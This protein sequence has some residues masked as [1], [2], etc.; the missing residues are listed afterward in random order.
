MESKINKQLNSEQIKK[1]E[2]ELYN[3]IYEEKKYLFQF[4]STNDLKSLS[5]FSNYNIEKIMFYLENFTRDE[6]L[7]KIQEFLLSSN[8]NNIK[9]V[10]AIKKIMQEKY[11]IINK[12]YDY[13]EEFNSVNQKQKTEKFDKILEKPWLFI[14]NGINIIN[15]QDALLSFDKAKI[16]SK[17]KKEITQSNSKSKSNLDNIINLLTKKLELKEKKILNLYKNSLEDEDIEYLKNRE[18]FYEFKNN[19]KIQNI[20]ENEKIVLNYIYKLP[21]NLRNIIFSF[22]DIF[23]LGKLGLTCKTFY[24]FIYK[25]YNFNN[26]SAKIYINAIFINSNLYELNAKTIKQNYKNNLD[27][28]K[29]KP[30]IRFGGIYYCRLKTIKEFQYYGEE[31][32]NNDIIIYR[33]L[34]FLP[35]GEVYSMTSPNFKNNKIKQGIKNGVIELKKG[36]YKIKENDTI[37]IINDNN[38]EYIY[39]LGWTDWSKYRIGY[40]LGNDDGVN[41][42]IELLNYFMINKNKERIE[43]PLNENFPRRFRFRPL[44]NLK[45]ELFIQKKIE[46]KIEGN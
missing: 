38:D 34:R 44:N 4:Y 32:H 39:K 10:K 17:I 42:G 7:K 1:F 18:D 2:E 23:T 29:H 24:N 19:N 20:N 40:L 26:E 13:N 25:Q 15:I 3:K 9:E 27:L 41:K 12:Y 6:N 35:N 14:F 45:N 30:R 33:F 43:I 46:I 8:T 22:I 31:T 36:R 5:S 21:F 37:N 28:I 11:L 16:F